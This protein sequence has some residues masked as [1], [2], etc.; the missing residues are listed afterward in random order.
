MSKDLINPLQSLVKKA[1][2]T[3]P[4]TTGK[5]AIQQAKL[6]RRSGTTVILADVSSSMESVAEDGRRKID[7]LR[8]AVDAARGRARLIAFSRTVRQVEQ[9]PEPEANTD[10][11][12]GLA[13][14]KS[15]DPGTTIL[16]SDGEPDNESAA[17]AQARNFRGAIDV[18]YIG[19]EANARAIDFMRRLAAAAGGSVTINDITAPGGV[20]LL[21]QRIAGLL[22]RPR[23]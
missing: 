17:L 21:Q 1:A 16:I 5:T 19:P 9:I 13:F 6:D 10:L 18:L 7:I 12:A 14:A 15:L 11:A 22:P 3:L 4:A 20:R 2:Q 23:A 8:D